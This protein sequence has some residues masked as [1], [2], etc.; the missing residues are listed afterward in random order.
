MS[1]GKVTLFGVGRLGICTGL[2]LEKAGYEVLGIDVNANYVEKINSRTLRSPEP[3]VSEMLAASKNFRATTNEEDDERHYDCS[4]LSSVL[5]SLNKRKVKNKHVVICCTVL[6]GYCRSVAKM[7]LR[8]CENTT[9]SYNPEFIA[10]GDVINGLLRPDMVLIG[11]GTEAAGDVLEKL[12]RDMVVNEPVVKRMSVESAEICKL[13]VN[14]F[15]TTK[16][17]FANM[18]GDTADKTPGADASAILEAIGSDSR[19][20]GKCLK[21][22][23]GFGGPCFPRDNRALGKHIRNVGIA[24]LLPEATDEA[25]KQHTQLQA[26]ALLETGQ[27]EFEFRDVAYKEGCRV[28]I[29]EESQKLKIAHILA[30][31]NRKVTIRDRANIIL[32]VQQQ[33]G[34][35][36]EYTVE[37]EE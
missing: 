26:Q 19:I 13:A 25:N 5:S 10:Q 11:Q 15:I 30:R 6:P 33:Y 29:I 12:Y 3:R 24:P 23:Y 28:P 9:L 22:G 32:A 16:I 4:V 8:D 37:E 35:A 31:A 34:Y 14:C 21:P 36:F 1:K 20:G 17:A 2:C 7:L 18:I 27:Q